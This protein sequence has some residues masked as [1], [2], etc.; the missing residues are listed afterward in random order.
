MSANPFNESLIQDVDDTPTEV[1]P[2][3]ISAPP[4]PPADPGNPQIPGQSVSSCVC[5]VLRD[6]LTWMKLA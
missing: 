2:Q 3:W 6:S 5:F 1:N 4:A